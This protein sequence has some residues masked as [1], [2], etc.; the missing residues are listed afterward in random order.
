FFSSRRRHT[1]SKRDWSSDVCS[2][3]LD[4]IDTS[5]QPDTVTAE[6]YRVNNIETFDT[7]AVQLKTKKDVDIYF[8]ASHAV[9]ENKDPC[10]QLEFENATITYDGNKTAH[11]IV[12]I[13]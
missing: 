13:W 4:T 1:R 3:D 5:G 6:L 8:Y 10:F 11:N 12:A 2:S 7:C 9:K